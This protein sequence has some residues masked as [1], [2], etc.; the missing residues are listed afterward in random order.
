ML[1]NISEVVENAFRVA[2]DKMR[3]AAFVSLPQDILSE[4]TTTV[5]TARLAA[6]RVWLRADRNL[7]ASG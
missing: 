7:S 6:H 4:T 5:G 1:E 3:G 2:T